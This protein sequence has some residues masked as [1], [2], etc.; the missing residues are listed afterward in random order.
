MPYANSSGSRLLFLDWARIGAFGLLVLYHVGMYYVTWDWHIKSP[1]AGAAIEPLMR[2]VSPWRLDLLFLVSGA[3]TA[4]MLGRKGAVASL[5]RARAA[6]LLLP[7]VFGMLVIVPPQS[8]FEVVEKFGYH[9]S[10]ADFMRL[11]LTG[12]RD[13]CT[14]GQ[15]LILPTW[16]HLWF[17]PYLFAYT[18]VLW[19]LLR[20]APM[21][22]GAAGRWMDRRSSGVLVAA[23]V[24]YLVAT[25]AFLRRFPVT[26]AL[27]DDWFSHAQYLA[28]FLLGAALAGTKSTWQRFE[29]LRAPALAVALACWVLLVTDVLPPRGAPLPQAALRAVVY[30]AQ[31]WLM[32]VAVLG[33]AHRY[34]NRDSALRRT[35][36]EAVFPVYVLHQTLTILLARAIAPAQLPQVLEAAVLVI[37]TFVLSFAGYL[38]VRRIRWVRPL[39]GLKRDELAPRAVSPSIAAR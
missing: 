37:G 31:Q 24:I 14:A 28:F 17:L 15:C 19:L 33:F 13:F 26:H 32:L 25:L 34:L 4:F 3:A 5:L 22:A 2:L 7:L 9:G 27:V 29:D 1:H 35:F 38:I 8:Y 30:S 36:T 6:R 10:F 11:Y 18:C 12:S 39:F 20:V 16:N 23:P 21:L